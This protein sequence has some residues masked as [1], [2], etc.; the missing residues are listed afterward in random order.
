M[1]HIMSDGKI[2][3]LENSQ[4]VAS[5]RFSELVSSIEGF[6]TKNNNTNNDDEEFI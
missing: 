4:A 3:L 5:Q 6:T 2:S 1:K